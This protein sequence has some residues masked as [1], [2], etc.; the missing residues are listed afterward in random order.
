MHASS[1][2]LCLQPCTRALCRMCGPAC[3]S[4]DL[5]SRPRLAVAGGLFVP[6][7]LQSSQPQVRP[8]NRPCPRGLDRGWPSAGKRGPGGIGRSSPWGAG[9]RLGMKGASAPTLVRWR[10]I[11]GPWGLRLHFLPRGLP[12]SLEGTWCSHPSR[13]P[14]SDSPGMGGGG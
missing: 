3:P 13:P 7:L 11:A 14:Q 5:P 12:S 9:G 2:S 4:H 8:L 10:V 1:S 6:S